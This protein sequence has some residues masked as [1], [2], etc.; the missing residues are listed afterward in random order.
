MLSLEEVKSYY[1]NFGRK[2]DSQSFYEDPATNL[3]IEHGSFEEAHS[4]FEF[5]VGTGRFAEKV[6]SDHAPSDCTYRGI[7][8]SETMIGVSKERLQRF[9]RQVS[10]ELSN[11]E[12]GLSE[13]DSHYD[14]FISNYVL[15][16]MTRE[17]AQAVI[18]EAHRVLKP[19]GLLCVVSLTH[20]R[21]IPA[22][23]VSGIWSALFAVNARLVGGCRPIELHTVITAANWNTEFST[24]KTSFGLTSE[25]VIARKL[26]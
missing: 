9:E 24:T 7:D 14:R 23:I 5:G 16:L 22:K 25:I 6:L 10:I 11:G 26:G 18:G 21:T 15:D 1:D 20:G 4:V 17:A 8:I 19:G 12:T 2:Q 13:H 3:L